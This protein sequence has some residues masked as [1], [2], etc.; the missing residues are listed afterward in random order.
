MKESIRNALAEELAALDDRG[1]FVDAYLCNA[2]FD[3]GYK[4]VSEKYTGD[5]VHALAA[6]IE[7]FDGDIEQAIAAIE[8]GEYR[9]CPDVYSDDY[10]ELGREII[11]DE[12]KD[13]PE[14]PELVRDYLNLELLG[15]EMMRDME[16]GKFTNFGYFAPKKW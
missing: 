7:F 9:H 14:L 10:E 2:L 3:E 13:I 15:R 6:A 1:F 8:R 4:F 16:R 11:D 5:E 12:T